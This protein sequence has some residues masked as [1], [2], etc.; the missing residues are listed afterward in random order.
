M[1]KLI[2]T[3]LLLAAVLL[4]LPA[5]ANEFVTECPTCGNPNIEWYPVLL[6]DTGEYAHHQFCRDCYALVGSYELCTPL[7]GSGTCFTPAYCSV[8]NTYLWD[9]NTYNPDVHYDLT[10]WLCD[11]EHEQHYRF[12]PYCNSESSYE[13]EAHTGGTATCDSYAECTDC[14][15]PYG[16]LLD[17]H[18]Y[19]NW[20]PAG[21]GAHT[22][23][24]SIC[25]DSVSVACPVFAAEGFTVCPICGEY[26]GGVLPVLIA[27]AAS[28][29]LPRGTL[30]VRGGEI[31]MDGVTWAITVAGSYAGECVELRNPEVVAIPTELT[32]FTLV[33]VDMADGAEVRTEVPFT[34]EN[35][36]LTFTA[37]QI[38]LFLL[39]PTE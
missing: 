23:C 29:S 1:K 14:G 30:I 9:T 13:Y 36:K 18:V 16:S 31:P 32:G 26:A 21:D 6:G 28:A 12:C 33:R 10:D 22:G 11:P 4:A 35:G 8:C 7:E 38:G 37:E 27:D 34:L 25:N 24:C 19:N 39:L 5:L 17:Q 2:V 3:L 20:A 15:A